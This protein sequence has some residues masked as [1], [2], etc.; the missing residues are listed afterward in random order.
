MSQANRILTTYI[1]N[2]KKSLLYKQVKRNYQIPKPFT[3]YDRVSLDLLSNALMKFD[4]QGE[5]LDY[6]VF[7]PKYKASFLTMLLKN[8]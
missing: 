8:N 7:Q 4:L 6:Q 3:Q 1:K 2:A 5:L